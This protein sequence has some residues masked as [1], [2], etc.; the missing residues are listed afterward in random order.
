MEN[1]N[2]E[3]LVEKVAEQLALLEDPS[4]NSS[5]KFVDQNNN[6]MPRKSGDVH[7][8]VTHEVQDHEWIDDL[9]GTAYSASPLNP[10]LNDEIRVKQPGVEKVI[11]GLVSRMAKIWKYC[12][13][14]T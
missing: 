9:K 1:Q 3:F 8:K 4:T 10:S 5:E 12:W 13:K 6:Y 2:Q 7:V 11:M 14:M